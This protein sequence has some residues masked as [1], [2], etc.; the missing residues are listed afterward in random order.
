ME[1]SRLDQATSSGVKETNSDGET[2]VE[3][4]STMHRSLTNESFVHELLNRRENRSHEIEIDPRKTDHVKSEDS[5]TI[6]ITSDILQH[7]LYGKR[8]I[9]TDDEV[10]LL[11]NLANIPDEVRLS[12]SRIPGQTLGVF[13]NTWICEGTKMGPI[14]GKI[15][16]TTETASDNCWAWEVFDLS[17]DGQLVHIVDASDE[18][19]RCWLHYVNCARHEQEQNL[20]INI[21]PNQELLVWYGTSQRLYLGVPGIGV[22]PVTDT[23]QRIGD[24]VTATNSTTT[25]NTNNSNLHCVLCQR[26]FN[27]RS[28]LRSHMRTHTLERPFVCRFCHRRFSQSSTLRN[29]VRLHTGPLVDRCDTDFR[30]KSPTSVW[31]A[32]AHIHNWLGYGRIKKVRDIG[33]LLPLAK[34]Y[35]IRFFY[36][37][38][39]CFSKH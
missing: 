19:T 20:E 25:I 24:A 13:S 30:V 15:L 2:G 23:K 38:I 33:L 35:D 27:S 22:V 31:Y 9:V 10:L 1:S 6:Q 18:K 7:A 36:F 34:I 37:S 32:T 28:N 8:T 4:L 39:G 17:N 26:G 16:K 21:P 5:K 14:S 11:P 3:S 12:P 29:H